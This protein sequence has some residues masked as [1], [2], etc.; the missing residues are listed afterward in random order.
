MVMNVTAG[1]LQ[2]M[3]AGGS[4]RERPNGALQTVSVG[5]TPSPWVE[6]DPFNPEAAD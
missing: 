3:S 5:R 4:M 2:P 6:Y 1:S